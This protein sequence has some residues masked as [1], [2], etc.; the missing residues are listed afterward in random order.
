M[1]Q[2]I[3]LHLHS[4]CSDG[5]LS[6]AEVVRRSVAAGLKAIALT[7]HDNTDGI[8]ALRTAGAEQGLEILSGVE[9]SVVW[10]HWQDIHLLGYGFDHRHSAL[11]AALTEFQLF[12]QYRNQQIVERV[13]DKL[14]EENQPPLDFNRVLE[15]AG[16]TIGRPHI[17]MAL[18]EAGIVKSTEEAFQRYLIACNVPKRF[19]QVSEAIDL[20]HAAGG[21]AVLAHPPFIT[22]EREEFR[23]LLDELVALGLDGVEVYNSGASRSGSDWYLTEARR[24]DLIVTG[25]SDF[26][27]LPG[28]KHEIGRGGGQRIPYACVAEIRQRAERYAVSRRP[29]GVQAG[30]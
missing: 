27:G 7:D 22:R 13:N 24:R 1:D 9:L 12:R 20:I 28:E 19:F 29:K 23:A 3:D 8:D 18:H 17:A 10:R 25:G 2:F 11:V 4:T 6:P 14:A 21:V 15:L 26:H 5:A 16:G 30:S